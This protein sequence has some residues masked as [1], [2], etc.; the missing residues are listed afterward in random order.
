MA[1]LFWNTNMAAMTSYGTA[2]HEKEGRGERS[3]WEGRGGGEKEEEDNNSTSPLKLF[4]CYNL[5]IN[6]ADSYR[7]PGWHQVTLVQNKNQM[8]VL[9]LFLHEGFN[10]TGPCPHW[11][12]SI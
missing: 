4:A 8:F 3:R 9:L 6:M 2:L 1:E 12:T 5:M 10:M 11:I 7:Y